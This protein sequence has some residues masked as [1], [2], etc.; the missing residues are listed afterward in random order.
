MPP[1]A[2]WFRKKHGDKACVRQE[3]TFHVGK[4]AVR[5]VELPVQPARSP[6][7]ASVPEEI[8]CTPLIFLKVILSDQGFLIDSVT[9]LSIFSGTKYT[10][11]HGVCIL[12]ADGSP[13]VCSGTPII[14][15]HFSCGSGSK[16]YTWNFQ[17][18][19][20]SIPLLGADFL[21]HFNLLVEIKG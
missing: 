16:V 18:A 6:P 19:P 15:L 5:Q 9:S 3:T 4:L 17:L 12:T 13:M 14:P 21:S 11:D 20:V 7:L 10:T 2:C 8:C 1:G